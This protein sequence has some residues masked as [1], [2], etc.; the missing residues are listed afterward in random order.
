MKTLIYAL[1][2]M[3]VSATFLSGCEELGITDKLLDDLT[4]GKMVVRINEDQD[5][6]FNCTF[7]HY[8][9]GDG[10][11]GEVFING[12]LTST[13]EKYLTFIYGSYNNSV[14]LTKK[15]YSTNKAEDMMTISTSYGYIENGT[16]VTVTIVE[17]TDT[18]IKG[19]F[20]GNLSTQ[21]GNVIIDGA[22]WA[23]KEEQTN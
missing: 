21:D 9:E 23:S 22:F 10:L 3:V 14:A 15:S 18:A 5:E 2:F 1:I 6:T 17:T 19:T 16:A 13:T 8:G 4:T 11:T 20:T 12:T 7:T